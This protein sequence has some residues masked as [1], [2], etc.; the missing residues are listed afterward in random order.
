MHLIDVLNSD[1]VAS[2]IHAVSKKRALEMA[3][4]HLAREQPETDQRAI[5]EGLCARE[6]LGS[7]ALG[8]GVAIPH[9]RMDGLQQPVGVLMRLA[10]AVEFD[11]ADHE[12]VDLMFALIVPEAAS[13]EHL[14][15]LS[16]VAELFGDAHR[17]QAVRHAPDARAI[18]DLVTHWQTEP[19]D[20]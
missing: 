16:Q 15:L 20:S 4:E 9:A 1:R 14:Q 19:Q 7:T 6:K 2:G 17:R 10:D 12:P 5:L 18:Y 13:E 8:H 11:A 3:S